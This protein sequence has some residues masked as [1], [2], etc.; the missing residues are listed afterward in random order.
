MNSQVTSLQVWRAFAGFLARP[1][2]PRRAAGIDGAAIRHTLALY[3]LDLVLMVPLI[4]VALGAEAMGIHMPENA[5][6]SIEI[7]AMWIAV[8]VLGAPLSEEVLF[9][10]WLSGRPG[11]VAAVA[12]LVLGFMGAAFAAGLGSQA[13]VLAAGFGALAL[14]ALAIWRG[15]RSEPFRFYSHRFRW[16]FYAS[17]LAFAAIHLL[18]YQ[19]EASAL[20]VVPQF[21]AGLIFGY[22]RVTNGLWSSIALH[23]LH[24]A[25]FLTLAAIGG[26]LG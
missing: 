8:I 16:F 25:T 17:A 14:A 1:A 5:L 11:H 4:L 21:V 10:G 15:R 2:L 26:Q 18:N 19:G 6:D 20:L 13:G 12:M 22:A 3:G 23:A 24:N 9:R 7:D